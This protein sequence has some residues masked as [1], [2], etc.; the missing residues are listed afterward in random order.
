M[1]VLI[2][3]ASGQ[4]GR[5]LVAR[6]GA[7]GWSVV[8]PPRTEVDLCASDALSDAI[9]RS[10]ADAVINAAAFTAV[11]A[12]ETQIGAAFAV[13]AAGPTRIARACADQ[14]RPFV[15]FSTD[16]VFDGAKAAPYVEADPTGPRSIYG[17]SKLA[18]EIGVAAA[19]EDFAILRTSWVYSASGHNF[20]KTMLRLGRERERLQIV[21]DQRGKPTYAEDLAA[22]ALA[23]AEALAGGRAEARGVFHFAGDAAMSWADFAEQIFELSK[24]DVEI[25]RISTAEF[26]APAPRPANSVLACDKF[27]G[28]FG[29]RP[30]PFRDALSQTLKSLD[31]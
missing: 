26:G 10:G 31:T 17:A 21:G 4:T 2:L 22:A 25:E 5:A 30:T 16:Y 20:V 6:A 18:G 23:A 13:N 3:G 11:D 28:A 12:A 1:R 14:K 24:I 29:V 8:A 9:A 7:K 19:M 15:H 27:L